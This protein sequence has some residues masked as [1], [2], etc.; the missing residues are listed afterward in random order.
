[1]VC[2]LPGLKEAERTLMMAAAHCLKEAQERGVTSLQT[3]ILPYYTNLMSILE[4]FTFLIQLSH[5]FRD[6]LAKRFSF[7]L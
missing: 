4:N 1:M 7:Y 5:L 2:R 3:I 6:F